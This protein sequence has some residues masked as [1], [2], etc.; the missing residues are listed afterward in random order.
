MRRKH[1]HGTLLHGAQLV[2]DLGAA[3]HLEHQ[4]RLRQHLTRFVVG[5]HGVLERRLVAAGDDGV[6]LGVHQRH[7]ALEGRHEV[8]G[9]DPVEGRHA[10]GRVPCREEG[11]FAPPVGRIAADGGDEQEERRK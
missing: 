10:V 3:Q 7:A 8:P 6:D 5:Q 9:A 4:T 11:V 2:V 1:G